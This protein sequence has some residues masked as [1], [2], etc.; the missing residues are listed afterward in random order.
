MAQGDYR[1]EFPDFPDL[2]TLGVDRLPPGFYDRS[3]H[4]DALP[5][6]RHDGLLVDLGVN[7]PYPKDR[8]VLSGWQFCLLELDEHGD[9]TGEANFQ[10]W[11]QVR[12][13]LAD[14]ALRHIARKLELGF[15]PD[16]RLADYTHPGQLLMDP[17]LRDYEAWLSEAFALLADPYAVALDEWRRLG[18]VPPEEPV[19]P[20]VAAPGAV[21]WVV[22]SG[23]VLDRV[24]DV[25]VW[26]G[27]HQT[28][29]VAKQHYCDVSNAERR[30]LGK[31]DDE[32]LEDSDLLKPGVFTGS[33]DEGWTLYD[34]GADELVFINRVRVLTATE[35]AAHVQQAAEA[36][37]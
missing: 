3:W 21:A 17:V 26:P 33:D 6:F 18:L 10:T 30:E 14:R 32:P 25:C 36:V 27:A 22:I 23:N 5:Y 24:R 1:S 16:T 7:Y 34:E 15:H 20:D 31:T 19:A 11:L 35:R 12:T 4:N 29:T 28:A 2:T 9:P 37:G 13:F 8:E